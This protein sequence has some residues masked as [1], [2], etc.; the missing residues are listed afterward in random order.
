MET[1]RLEELLGKFGSRRI[2]VLGDYFLDRYLVTDPQ[3]A[4]KSIETGKT[5]HQVVDIRNAPGA[6]GT[7]V[8]N[9]AALGAGEL[10]AIGVVGDDGQGYDLKKELNRRGCNTE[11]LIQ[12]ANLMT[13]TYLKPLNKDV[14]GLEGEHERYDT[15]N[16]KT[17]TQRLVNE[18]LEV[19]DRLL[20]E[21]DAVIVLDQVEE[22][23]CGVLTAETRD[24][25]AERAENNPN[26][27]FYADSRRYI[28]HFRNM[29]IK[30]NEFEAVGHENPLPGDQVELTQ[31]EEAIPRL[32]NTAN[33]PI[34]VTRGANGIIVSDPELTSIPGIKLE[35]PVDTTGA[36]D[37]VSAGLVLTLASGAIL[38]EAALVGMLVASIT[39]KQL[40]TTG[41]ASQ[42]Q[43]S[44]RLIMWKSQN[45]S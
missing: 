5:A 1:E 24:A 32:R 9:L 45:E 11:G 43:V 29:I 18:A 13:P 12:S 44:E 34:C 3:L 31:L 10:F 26:V 14:P 39:V 4:E 30:P 27:I 8:N 22:E 37:S 33:A 35:G 19:L 40:G 28:H 36:G 42:E 21:L 38:P 16:R 20:P 6:A 7:I 23:N 2:A 15:K 41:T 25:L 17:M